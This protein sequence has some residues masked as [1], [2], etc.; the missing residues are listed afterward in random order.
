MAEDFLSQDEVDALLKGAIGEVDEAPKEEVKDG[1]QSYD[2]ATQERIVRG[3]MPTYEILNER[4]ARL[5]RMGLFNFMRRTVDISVGPVKIIKFSEFVR[6]LVVPTNLN[7]VQ[8]KPLRGTALFVFDPNLIFLIVDT[9]FGGDGRYHTRVEGRD[10]TQTEQRIIQ[11][12]ISVVFENYEKTW[13]SVYPLKF[14][15]IRSEMNPQFATIATPNEVV[16]IVTYDIDLG[17]KGG[18]LHVC[19]PYSMIEPIR[20]VLSSALQGDHMEVDKRW[21]SLLQQQVQGAEVELIANLGHTKVTFDQ[22]LSMQAGDIIPLEI[23]KTIKAHVDGVPVMDCRYGIINGR[24]ALRVDAMISPS[25][26]D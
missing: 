14:E 1:V 3:R 16:V 19:I 4:F 6:N 25:E 8:M 22:I 5:L 2:L 17:N 10:F 7:M 26:A 24:Y 11:R 21:V 20:D 23:P 15:Y 18:A 12:L 13:Q 9:L